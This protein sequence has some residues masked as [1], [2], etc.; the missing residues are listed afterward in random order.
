MNFAVVTP[1]ANE[2]N[3]FT[4][5]TEAVIATFDRIGNGCCYLVVDTVSKDNTLELCHALSARDSRFITVWAPE[6]RNVVQAYMVGYRTA[7]P[8][9]HDFIIEMTLGFHTIRPRSLCF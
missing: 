4:P 8:A 2:S 5:F 7:L 6:N 3:E 1:L 9:V